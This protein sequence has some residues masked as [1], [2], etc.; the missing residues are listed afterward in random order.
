VWKA[1][2]CIDALGARGEAFE[3]R[4]IPNLGGWIFRSCRYFH[5]VAWEASALSGDRGS[6]DRRIGG[7]EDHEV[8]RDGAGL[9]RKGGPESRILINGE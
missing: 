6:E 9:Q 2:L 7:P 8:I 4:L 3:R 5:T 1:G